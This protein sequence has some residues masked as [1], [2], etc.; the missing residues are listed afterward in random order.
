MQTKGRIFLSNLTEEHIARYISQS[1]DSE[2]IETMGWKP[3]HD[4]EKDRFLQTAEI[5]TVPYCK[6]GEAITL[7]IISAIDKK[8]IGYL[9]IKGINRVAACAEIGI[10]IMDKKYRGRGYGTEAL[11]KAIDHACDEFGITVLLLTVFPSNK[12]A[13]RCYEKAGF[14]KKELLK[15]SWLLPSGKYSDMWLMELRHTI[16]L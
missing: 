11:Q 1:T 5:P 10:A 6:N 9:S 12:K 7:S 8:A 4:G 15:D 13:I 16:A 14:S 3:F 2:L